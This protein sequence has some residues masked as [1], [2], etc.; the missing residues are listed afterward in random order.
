MH[1]F[2]N[3]NGLE[4]DKHFEILGIQ[5]LLLG[6][7]SQVMLVDVQGGF[8]RGFRH[9]RPPTNWPVSFELKYS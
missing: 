7:T 3:D 8:S 5:M 1:V 4:H 6:Q 2:I 9:F